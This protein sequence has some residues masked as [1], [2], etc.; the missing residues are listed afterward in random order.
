M[1]DYLADHGVEEKSQG[2]RTTLS[3]SRRQKQSFEEVVKVKGKGAYVPPGGVGAAAFG[4]DVPSAKIT[5]EYVVYLLGLA[6][7]FSLPEDDCLPVHGLSGAVAE[8]G[9]VPTVVYVGDYAPD[10]VEAI[11]KDHE[12]AILLFRLIFDIIE[13]V[14]LFDTVVSVAGDFSFW[15]SPELTDIDLGPTMRSISL[16]VPEMVKKKENRYYDEEFRQDALRLVAEGGPVVEV[17][18]TLGCGPVLFTTGTGGRSEKWE[19]WHTP[20]QAGKNW[21]RKRK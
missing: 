8:G 3:V 11:V 12:A 7:A 5:L 1:T 10:F 21:P 14:A 16:E 4:G 17:A 15:P 6:A 9:T 13:Q 2:F 18:E 20:V 19:R